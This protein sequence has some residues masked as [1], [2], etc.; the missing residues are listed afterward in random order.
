MASFRKKPSGKIEA[1]VLDHNGRQ[2]ARSFPNMTEAKRWAKAIEVDVRRGDYTDKRLGSMTFNEWADLFLDSIQHL[3]E[4]TRDSHELKL[5]LHVRP[6][7]GKR[8]VGKITTIEIR[9]LFSQLQ[10]GG[11]S[12]AHV[13]GVRTSMNRVFE[14]AREGESI[15]ANPC[16]G[17]T[18]PKPTPAKPRFLEP[19]E[20]DRLIGCVRKPYDR[21]VAA[22]IAGGFR[23]AEIC[24]LRVRNLDV[25]RSTITI[26]SSLIVVNGRLEAKDTTKTNRTRTVSMP[27]AIMESLAEHC[28][29]RSHD[30]GRPLHA[31]DFVFT[32]PMGGPLARDRFFKRIFQP[33]VL[34]AGLDPGLRMHDLRHTCAAILIGQGV[35]PKAIQEMLGHKSITVTM[36]VY[37]HLFP[38]VSAGIGEIMGNVLADAATANRNAGTVRDI[39]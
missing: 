29:Q 19:E 14:L 27:K 6:T 12:I 28:A 8:P 36:D 20:A 39:R 34:A 13:R 2:V 10:A 38:S 4:T 37:G 3:S 1:R 21:L 22:T 15:K 5:R 26:D 11:M 7:F 9:T 30:L 31:D 17:I 23:P 25:L 35:H 24:G 33:A 16:F 18:L 32:A